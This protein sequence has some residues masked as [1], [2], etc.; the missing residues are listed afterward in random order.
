MA[1]DISGY[2]PFPEPSVLR[3]WFV[4]HHSSETELWVQIF[5]KASGTPSVTW[6]DV[7]VEALVWGWIDGIKKR[8]DETSYVQRITPRR[9]KSSW[10]KRNC[11]HV[12]RLV[13]EGLMMPSGLA[14]VDAA[15]ADGRWDTAYAG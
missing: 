9:S 14:Q 1:F 5:K 13:K 7:V 3:A 2:R 11:D 15:K 8:L 6:D 12:D 10:S 4:D